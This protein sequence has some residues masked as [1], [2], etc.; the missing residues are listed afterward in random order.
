MSPACPRPRDKSDQSPQKPRIQKAEGEETSSPTSS[1][2]GKEE[3]VSNES[4]SMKELLEQANTML[5]SLTSSTTTASSSSTAGA[6]E[7]K[8]EVMDR[9]QQQLNQLKLKVFKI[10]Q[11]SHG[12]HQGLIDS[13]ATHPLRPR[14]PGECDTTYKRVSVTLANGETTS[15][16]VTPG[17]IMVTDRHDVEPILPM[18]QLVQ[19]LQ[20]QVTWA[21]GILK[22][23]HP[24]RGPLP[25]QNRDGCPQIPRTLALDLIEEMETA[26]M[27]KK[28]KS[29][30]FE[31]EKKWMEDLVQS[32]PVLRDLPDRIK[33]RL[34]TD[35]GEWKDLP[36]NRRQRKRLQRDGFLVHLYAGESEGFTLSRAWKQQGGQ[37]NHLL[38]IDLKRGDGHNMLLDSG[39]YA[40]LLRAVLQDR[41]DAFVAGP[42]CRTRSVLRHY[43]KENAPRPV[44]AW[45]GEEHGLADLTPAEKTQVEEDDIL[46]WRF[47]FLWMIATYLRR[48]RQVQ[49]PVGFLLEQPASPKNYMPQCVSF[50]DTVQWMKL[51]EEFGFAETTFCQGHHGG[52]ATKPTTMAGNLQ[53]NPEDHRMK[54]TSST[55]IRSSSELSR[56]APGVMNMVAEALLTQIVN[57]QPRISSLSWEEHLRHGHIPF[58]RDCLVCQQSLQQQPPHRKVKHPLGGVLSIDT[59]GPFIRAYD[60]GGYQ[61]AYILVGALTWTVPKDSKIK[62]EEVP[63]LE[64]E[65]P[66]FE[67]KKDEEMIPIEDQPEQPPEEPQGIFGDEV[68]EDEER[69]RAP[70]G[71]DEVPK[72]ESGQRLEE[73]E[74][75][76]EKKEEF[77]TRVFRLAAPMY[78]K[79]ATEVTRVVMDMMLRLRADGYHIGH[80]HSDQGHEFQGHF[81]RWCRERGVLLTRTPGDDPRANGRAETAVKSLKT[82]IRRVLLQA[83]A[84][85]TW[86]PWATRY[87][88]ELN[89]AARLAKSPDWPPFLTEVMVRKRKWRR[90]TFEVSTENVK[91]LCP[92]PEEHGHWILPKDEAPRV[93]K[94][95]MKAAHLPLAEEGWVALEREA[96]DALDVRRRI[97][98]SQRSESFKRRMEEKKMKRRSGEFAC[99]A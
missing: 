14:R 59:T 8:D 52:A 92:A 33:S 37:E 79:K 43:P 32:H 1:T 60:A 89:R 54:K 53:L 42:N 94:L 9:L 11:I 66:S 29:V 73:K 81:K 47:I 99:S 13:G 20:C 77:E 98:E 28:M 76:A 72:E 82:Q 10:N 15:L 84:E 44:R 17:G 74:G 68:P 71:E 85:P 57:R 6:T 19:D 87:V 26:G 97:G 78:S 24:T 75:E 61:S 48:A 22:V 39:V 2:K 45:K 34:V 95:L 90:G 69:Q 25:V 83:Q 7:T 46:M 50:W 5:K 23:T 3:E 93:T 16:Q 70:E 49:K 96:V 86:W 51:K 35:I 55:A 64:G 56:W 62:E 58:R 18:G 91:Y 63:E 67:A 41:I 30:G 12:Q 40:G 21:D 27:Q 4:A 38:E 80:I 65:A 88:N 31:K 36:V